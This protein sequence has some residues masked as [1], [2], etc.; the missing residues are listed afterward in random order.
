MQLSTAEMGCGMALVLR[1]LLALARQLAV[2]CFS[3]LLLM[4]AGVSAQGGDDTPDPMALQIHGFVG[5]GF[6]VSTGN[7]FL[8]ESTRGSFE[9]SEVGVNLTQPL[10]HELRLGLQL[11]ARDFGN[12]GNYDVKADWFYID[13]RWADWLGV[14]AGRVKLP[15]G[16]YN[17]V[18]DI[19]AARVPVLLP[20][21]VYPVSNRDYLLA[22]T[23]GE[24]YGYIDLH[25]AGALD[26]RMYGGAIFVDDLESSNPNFRLTDVSIPYVV[27]G[28]LMYETPLEGLRVGGSLQA[29][30]L[31]MDAVIDPVYVTA[32]KMSGTLEA[33]ATGVLH[34]EVS[35]LLWIGSIEYLAYDWQIALEY[36][37]WN[38]EVE[39]NT[40]LLFEPE[41][42]SERMYALLAYRV[43]SWLQPAVYYSLY[44]P[45]IKR[46]REGRANRQH[47][48][49]LTLRFDIN[50]H[51]L[52]KLEG[53]YLDGTTGLEPALNDGVLAKD[54]Q[55]RWM[56]FLAKTTAYF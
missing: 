43:F 23:G 21:S 51:W 13:Y 16:L 55:R 12:L 17:E 42:L 19:D 26:Y 1:R 25:G 45:N 33:D 37:R 41:N 32:L 27:G 28:R 15:F 39:S 10:T 30:R 54:M 46:S 6:F 9:L 8:T 40:P 49:S 20:Q 53:H 47:D 14:R 50:E 52:I 36:S 2:L 48:V 22:Q 31:D 4:A 24:L 11:F 29:L 5:Q 44:F 18:H 35:G 34:A 3:L 7:N 56:L 38:L